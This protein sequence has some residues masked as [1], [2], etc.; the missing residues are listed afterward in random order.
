MPS[1]VYVR[2]EEIKKRISESN[3]GRKMSLENRERLFKHG[4]SHTRFHNIWTGMK[5]RCIDKNCEAFLRYGARGITICEEWLDFVNFKNDMYDSYLKHCEDFGEKQTS[6]DRKDNEGNYC[7]ENCRWA[8]AKE[9][10]ANTSTRYRRIEKEN[11]YKEYLK[12]TKDNAVSYGLFWNRI[13]IGF[14]KAEIIKMPKNVTWEDVC[15]KEFLE[16]KKDKI[17][18]LPNNWKKIIKYRFGLEGGRIRTLQETGDNFNLSRERVRQLVE[19]G[20]NRIFDTN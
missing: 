18:S 13:K 7:K 19:K 4:L 10:S 9:Q 1:G 20:V 5:Q 12:E 8:T 15:K 16:T 3:K 17:E 2:T 14:T 6:I 11:E